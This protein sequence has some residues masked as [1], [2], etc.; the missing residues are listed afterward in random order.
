MVMEDVSKIMETGRIDRALAW[1]NNKDVLESE[2]SCM[3]IIIERGSVWAATRRYEIRCALELLRSRSI[4]DS[5]ELEHANKLEEIMKELD[6]LRE[7]NL[8]ISRELV[9]TYMHYMASVKDKVSNIGYAILTEKRPLKIFITADLLNNSIKIANESIE[10]SSALITSTGLVNSIRKLS[11]QLNT[12]DDIILYA[13]SYIGSEL[14]LMDMINNDDVSNTINNHRFRSIKQLLDKTDELIDGL[15]RNTSSRDMAVILSG[16]VEA[17]EN[18]DTHFTTPDSI[19]MLITQPFERSLSLLASLKLDSLTTIY[20]DIDSYEVK[21]LIVAFKLK[22]D[23]L[24][25]LIA[26]EGGVIEKFINTVDAV[27]NK[28]D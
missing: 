23:M 4:I 28:E 8:L 12:L 11:S 24:L 6:D 26:L 5:E 25:D 15:V 19:N 22:I 13:N 17:I 21:R 7:E 16:A 3:S 1:A 9:D 20:D 2:E 14:V 18:T 10:H 27:I